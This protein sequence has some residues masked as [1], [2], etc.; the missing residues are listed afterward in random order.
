LAFLQLTLVKSTLCG[1]ICGPMRADGYKRKKVP[2]LSQSPNWQS[3]K[4]LEILLREKRLARWRV[5][6]S[7]AITTFG[8][9]NRRTPGTEAFPKATPFVE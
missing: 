2:R 8:K 1:G 9:E 6:T 5:G 7:L 4:G 3:W